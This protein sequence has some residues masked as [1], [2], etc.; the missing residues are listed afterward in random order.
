MK[1]FRVYFN[2][3]ADY[4]LVW[5]L[6]EGPGTEEKFFAEILIHCPRVCTRYEK[7][8]S[9]DVPSAWIECEGELYLMTPTIARIYRSSL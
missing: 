1:H 8:E 5:S 7:Q 6:D 9:K 4:P 2:S 3:H